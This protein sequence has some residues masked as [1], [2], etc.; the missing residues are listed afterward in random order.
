MA[1]D[2]KRIQ[3]FLTQEV[4]DGLKSKGYHISKWVEIQAR[5]ELDLPASK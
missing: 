5:K 4:I 2:K 1:T 3:I